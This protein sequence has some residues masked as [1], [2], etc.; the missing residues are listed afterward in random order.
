MSFLTKRI[1]HVT[2]LSKISP[3]QRKDY[4]LSVDPVIVSCDVASWADETVTLV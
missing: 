2:W 1:L 4:F 3:R